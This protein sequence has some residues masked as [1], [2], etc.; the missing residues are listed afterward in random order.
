M[1]STPTTDLAL[2]DM[3][4]A[5]ETVAKCRRRSSECRQIGL[6]DCAHDLLANARAAERWLVKA[7]RAYPLRCDANGAAVSD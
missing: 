4:V 2:R 5:M 1:P 7:G 3:E 6:P